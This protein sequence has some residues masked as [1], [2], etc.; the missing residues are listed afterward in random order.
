MYVYVDVHMYMQLHVVYSSA[1]KTRIR[2]S[3]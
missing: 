3:L 2:V 1:M